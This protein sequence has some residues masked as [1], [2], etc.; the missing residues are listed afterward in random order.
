MIQAIKNLLKPKPVDWKKPVELV[1]VD[2]TL[3]IHTLDGNSTEYLHDVNNQDGLFWKRIPSYK[4]IK[5]KDTID[6]LNAA[7]FSAVGGKRIRGGW[8]KSLR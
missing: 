5:D 8:V 2:H 6:A 7:Y 1:Y 4:T 3:I